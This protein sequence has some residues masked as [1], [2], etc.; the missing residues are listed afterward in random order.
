MFSC[1]SSDMRTISEYKSSVYSASTSAASRASICKEESGAVFTAISAPVSRFKPWKTWPYEPEPMA[2]PRF[3]RPGKTC[4]GGWRADKGLVSAGSSN[5]AGSSKK[6]LI[7][8]IDSGD[9]DSTSLSAGE[10]D[11]AAGGGGTPCAVEPRGASAL[12][13]DKAAAALG[14]ASGFDK[15]SVLGCASSLRAREELRCRTNSSLRGCASS[16]RSLPNRDG[17][18]SSCKTSHVA[19]RK[20]RS[21]ASTWAS[22]KASVFVLRRWA[23]SA[24]RI[25]RN[26]STIASASSKATPDAST[27]ATAS[28]RAMDWSSATFRAATLE[29]APIV[30][31]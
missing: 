2:L 23:A 28:L 29:P 15:S 8:C 27:I 17:A 1:D 16:L 25:A 31:R 3:Q 4:R 10:R 14:I 5:S 7:L 19:G 21:R 30:R 22:V 12:A 24:C 13:Y 6:A 18:A 11:A 9:R 26:R 20:P